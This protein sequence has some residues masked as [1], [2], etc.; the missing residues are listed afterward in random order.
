M[1]KDADAGRKQ[2]IEVI[3]GKSLRIILTFR[4]F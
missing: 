2:Q 4:E 1:T 3:A